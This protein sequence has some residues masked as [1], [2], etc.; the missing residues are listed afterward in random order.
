MLCV[1]HQ[2]KDLISQL[3]NRFKQNL[4]FKLYS[5][6]FQEHFTFINKGNVVPVHDVN[7]YW[8]SGGTVPLIL[9]LGTTWRLSGQLHTLATLCLGEE[10]RHPLTRKLGGSTETVA[11][12]RHKPWMV[13]PIA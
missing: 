13:Q 8:G 10:P 6:N 4:V 1:S 5:N 7:T 11:P 12:P 3:C 2:P 9:N